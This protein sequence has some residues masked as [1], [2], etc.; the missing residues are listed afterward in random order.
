MSGTDDWCVTYRNHLD[1]SG[2][3]VP[4]PTRVGTVPGRKVRYVNLQRARAKQLAPQRQTPHTVDA[5]YV[6]PHR[7][8]FGALSSRVPEPNCGMTGNWNDEK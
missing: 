1:L 4:Y 5:Y 3:D 7:A 8:I 2:R 6:I